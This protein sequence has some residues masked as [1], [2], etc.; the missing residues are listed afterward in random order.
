MNDLA[1][2]LSLL[3]ILILTTGS[4]VMAKTKH[5]VTFESETMINGTMVKAGT[6][7]IK[8]DDKAGMLEVIKGSKVVASAPVHLEALPRE[9]HKTK[10]HFVDN[11]LVSVTFGG[12][13]QAV[14]V[15]SHAGE[16]GS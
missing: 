6:Y 4:A 14:V 13:S 9:E 15:N 12:D 16:S 8:Y 5:N 1:R 10:L 2:R 11:E 3:L 7:D